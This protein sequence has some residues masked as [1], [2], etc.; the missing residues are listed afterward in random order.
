MNKSRE[1][2]ATRNKK[3]IQNLHQKYINFDFGEYLG[4]HGYIDKT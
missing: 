3:Y 4:V 2:K 1:K